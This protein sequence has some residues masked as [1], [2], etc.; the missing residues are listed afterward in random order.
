MTTPPRRLPKW[1]ELQ[2]LI[3]LERPK[4]TRAERVAAAPTIADLRRIARSR[5]PRAVFDYVDG[6]AESERSL[7]RSRQA[8]RDVEFRPRVLADVAGTTTASTVLGQP[9]EMPLICAP[10]G[11]TRMMHSAGEPAVVRAAEGAGVP[12][13]LSTMGTTSPEDVTAAAP[14]SRRWFQLYVWQD[15]DASMTLV[16][17][18][19]SSGFEALMFTVDTPVGG[20]RLRDVRNG[21]TVPPKLTLKTLVDMAAHPSWWIDLLTTEPLEFASLRAFEGTVSEMINM[22]FDPSISWADLDWLREVWDG[23]LIV[24]GI[25]TVEDA[26]QCVDSGADAIVVSNH[27]GRQLDRAPTP[28]LALPDIAAAV[29][30]DM[31]IYLDGGIVNG[32]DVIAGIAAGAMACRIGCAH[33]YGLGA[34]GEAGVARALTILQ[35]EMA[36]TMQ[37]LGVRRVEDLTPDHV[38]LPS[39]RS[40]G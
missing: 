26:R 10:T 35:S 14:G 25:Q 19:R 8:F 4:V 17:R 11:F 40:A 9:T 36:R 23:P 7:S 30:G 37:L 24:K 32:A 20:S 13:A 2:P 18:A 3:G 28:L 34:G 33:L 15:R 16:D 39:A 31:E 29:G 6:A 12:Y 21:L 5:A 1:S 38:V 22:L 27:G